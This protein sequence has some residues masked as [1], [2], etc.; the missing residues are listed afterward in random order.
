MIEGQV[1]GAL[2]VRTEAVL[3]EEKEPRYSTS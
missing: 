1:F 3:G 2:D